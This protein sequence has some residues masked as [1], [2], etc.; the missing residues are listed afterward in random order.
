VTIVAPPITRLPRS[1]RDFFTYLWKNLRWKVI[2]F[3]AYMGVRLQSKPGMLKPPRFKLD[4][5]GLVP[6]A[7]ALHR[8]FS[9]AVA[10]GDLA[11][12]GKITTT[13]Y[14]DKFSDI[15]RQ[16][17][18]GSKYGWELVKYNATWRLPRIASHRIMPLPKT[19]GLEQGAAIHQ[20]VVTIASRQRLV[21]LEQ[22]PRSAR[23]GI[24][25]EEW[26]EKS[27]REVDLTEHVVLTRAFDTK[28]TAATE[29]VIAGSVAETTLGQILEDEQFIDDMAAANAQAKTPVN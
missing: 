11:T 22:A 27:A 23:R 20:V 18:A 12:L 24:D 25:G 17:S 4:R 29:W 2:D 6:T 3:V 9:E 14:G 8:S 21:E 1:P 16:R 13:K 10:A 28:S 15:I 26:V 5:K 7:K 19:K